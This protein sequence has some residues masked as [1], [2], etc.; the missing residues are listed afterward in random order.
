LN[1]GVDR[2]RT[3]LIVGAG[4]GGLAAGIALRRAGWHIRIFERASAPRELGFGVGLGPNAIA[5]LRELGV[6]DAVRPMAVA[7][8]SAE[9]RHVDGRVIR[10]FAGRPGQLTS[11]DMPALI[12]RP[13][14]HGALLAAVGREAVEVDSEA[15][16]FHADGGGVRLTLAN[17]TTAVGD[18]LVGADGVGSGVR[19]QLH[20]GEPPPRPSRYFALR[21]ASA[22][23]ESLA[24]REAI[25]YFGRGIE[26]AVVQAGSNS[27]YWFL[28]LMEEDVK[29]GSMEAGSVL[30]RF[31]AG[32][33][34][35]F[36]AIAG[37]SAPAD[38]RLDHLLVRDPLRRW[39]AGPVTLLGDAAH[40]M[41]PH[42]GQGAAQALED[43]VGLGR[44]LRNTAN[45][46]TALRRYEDVRAR[47]TSRVV[48]MGPR[49]AR[50]TTT[51]SPVVGLLRNAAIRI[52]PETALVRAFT[53]A[54]ADPHR[55]LG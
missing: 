55:A 9:I 37:A 38:L 36:L 13:A 12:M 29:A 45:P 19:A 2:S 22:A 52:I 18:I 41:L 31:T 24:G 5:A 32:F 40:P 10:R 8:T 46:V 43:A 42:T 47:L 21:G 50:I 4:I 34:P 6:L 15:M 25:W 1:I 54:G 53:Q 35:Q 17:G 11:G 7:P 14:L 51:R 30:R 3:A 20:P 48:R 33:D 23:I 49:I 39:G 27:I 28:S 16:T 26:G 44:A